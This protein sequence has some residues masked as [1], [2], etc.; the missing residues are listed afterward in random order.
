M[1]FGR[2]LGQ[3]FLEDP[4]R[5]DLI[6]GQICCRSCCREAYMGRLRHYLDQSEA[7]F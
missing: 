7:N 1:V 4:D 2:L 3:A 6:A 5:I